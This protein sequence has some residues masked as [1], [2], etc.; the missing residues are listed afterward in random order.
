MDGQVYR[1]CEGCGGVAG[2]SPCLLARPLA[3]TCGCQS[4]AQ[5]KV[6]AF[7]VEPI[8]AAIQAV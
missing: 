6:A 2:C 3:L 5:T 4:L 7:A 1:Q 8:E